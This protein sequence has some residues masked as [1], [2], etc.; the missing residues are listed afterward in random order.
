MT[1]ERT[2]TEERFIQKK[3]SKT[4]ALSARSAHFFLYKSLSVLGGVPRNGTPPFFVVDNVPKIAV[5]E[6]VLAMLGKFL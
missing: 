6:R 3:V 2:Y 5:D 1:R 4:W